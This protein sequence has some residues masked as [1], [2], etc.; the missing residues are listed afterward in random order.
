MLFQGASGS[1]TPTTATRLKRSN[2]I[3]AP[4]RPAPKAPVKRRR[5]GRRVSYRRRVAS[6]PE[7]EL[8]LFKIPIEELAR[9]LEYPSVEAMEHANFRQEV[10]DYLRKKNNPDRYGAGVNKPIRTYVHDDGCI[11]SDEEDSS[12]GEESDSEIDSCLL[13]K[14][15]KNVRLFETVSPEPFPLSHSQPMPWLMSEDS[16]QESSMIAAIE[17]NIPDIAQFDD[18]DEAPVNIELHDESFVAEVDTVTGLQGL[19]DT[20]DLL[21]DAQVEVKLRHVGAEFW[22]NPGIF[23]TFCIAGNKFISC[24]FSPCAAKDVVDPYGLKMFFLHS[25]R[26]TANFSDPKSGVIPLSTAALRDLVINFGTFVTH[27]RAKGSVV[28][29]TDDKT[30]KT[31]NVAAHP[32]NDMKL[33][34]RVKCPHSGNFGQVWVRFVHAMNGDSLCVFDFVHHRVACTAS[35]QRPVQHTNFVVQVQTVFYLVKNVFPLMN[36]FQQLVCKKACELVDRFATKLP[37]F[38]GTG[39]E[40]VNDVTINP[41]V[42][43]E[44]GILPR[45]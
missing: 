42:S 2:A 38:P 33:G 5:G 8:D 16:S 10:R 44:M 23:P 26:S 15:N 37:N 30:G 29:V 41:T 18:D 6:F 35:G 25:G 13:R 11:H 7:E 36:E 34:D 9:R 1:K 3:R 28:Q 20:S 43:W 12:S 27:G 14:L 19:A 31:K 4:R 22:L 32:L 40:I 45:D 17:A 24:N 39:R 21:T